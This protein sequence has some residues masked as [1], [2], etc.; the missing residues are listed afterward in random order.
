[1][2]KKKRQPNANQIEDIDDK[3]K[4]DDDVNDLSSTLE[5]M[6]ID[7]IE[8]ETEEETLSKKMDKKIKDKERK[9]RDK[10]LDI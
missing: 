10:E 9:I 1:M 4:E 6:D 5:E 2:K 7:V 3:M 8:S